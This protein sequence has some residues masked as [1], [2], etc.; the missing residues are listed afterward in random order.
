VIAA[1]TTG[2]GAPDGSCADATGTG[3]GTVVGAAAVAITIKAVTMRTLTPAPVA[4][5]DGRPMP[6]WRTSFAFTLP[7]VPHAGSCPALLDQ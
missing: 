3:T 2:H 7:M 1:V 5:R 4:R 6:I